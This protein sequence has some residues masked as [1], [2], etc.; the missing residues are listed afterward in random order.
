M[1]L[2]RQNVPNPRPPRNRVCHQKLD[3]TCVLYEPTTSQVQKPFLL[4]N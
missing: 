4:G 1:V 3:A 2:W